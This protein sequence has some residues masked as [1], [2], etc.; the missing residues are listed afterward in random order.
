MRELLLQKGELNDTFIKFR[1]RILALNGDQQEWIT[2]LDQ[3]RKAKAQRKILQHSQQVTHIKKAIKQDQERE[4]AKLIE[5]PARKSLQEARDQELQQIEVASSSGFEVSTNPFVNYKSETIVHRQKVKTRK[6][7]QTP[8]T[9][10]TSATASLIQED[11]PKPLGKDYFISNNAFKTYTKIRTG[12]WKLA[13]KDLCNLF[14]KLGCKVDVS[15]GKGDH[16]KITLPLDITIK[17]EGNL[18]AV[19]PEFITK[20]VSILTIPNWDSKW[21]GRVPPYM[22][23]SILAA[24]NALGAIDGTVHKSTVTFFPV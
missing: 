4:K 11:L 13:R 20:E 21:D 18:V 7:I 24:L 10:A 6:T 5:A 12:N 15:Q 23:K 1:A 9:E 17:K 16:T 8:T 3:Y 22:T 19:L 2:L 14:E